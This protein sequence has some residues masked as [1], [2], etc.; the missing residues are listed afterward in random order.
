MSPSDDPS[1]YLERRRVTALISS[2]SIS[3]RE[4]LASALC[5]PMGEHSPGVRAE[6]ARPSVRRAALEEGLEGWRS[7][8]LHTQAAHA[9]PLAHE[10]WLNVL[11]ADEV[12]LEALCHHW[13]RSLPAPLLIKGASYGA[14]WGASRPI[15]GEGERAASDLDVLLP[16]LD[17]AQLRTLKGLST[18]ASKGA[19][20]PSASPS[21]ERSKGAWHPSALASSHVTALHLNGLLIEVHHALAP[22]SCWRGEGELSAAQ[23]WAEGEEREL[24]GTQGERLR[25]RQPSERARLE[26][27]LVQALKTGGDVGLRG[28]CD[29]GRL[30]AL[31]KDSV[32]TWASRPSWRRSGL[33]ATLEL[34]LL[35]LEATPFVELLSSELLS[36]A[37]HIEPQR[38]ERLRAL[39]LITPPLLSGAR[40]PL[41]RWFVRARL[42]S[43]RSSSPPSPYA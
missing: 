32:L 3:A 41:E 22:L 16:P 28:W 13:P 24:E 19:W 38:R 21:V 20:H 26:V 2:L 1:L 43:E 33:S 14:R 12:R 11:W 8:A 29:L 9:P 31:N 37:H 18:G 34:S 23:M 25:V 39:A 5:C 6:L 7:L 10:A 4:V 17:Q 30:I 40:A 42:L 36:Y 35:T 15:W 27:A